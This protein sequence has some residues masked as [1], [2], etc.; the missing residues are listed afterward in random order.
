[1]LNDFAQSFV[2]YLDFEKLKGQSKT[3]K[4]IRTRYKYKLFL[5]RNLDFRVMLLLMQGLAAYEPAAD[6]IEER[7]NSVEVIADDNING[8]KAQLLQR[9]HRFLNVYG[10]VEYGRIEFAAFKHLLRQVLSDMR[11]KKFDKYVKELLKPFSNYWRK[12]KTK[13]TSV[14]KLLAEA[15]CVKTPMRFDQIKEREPLYKKA[16][17]KRM[18]SEVYQHYVRHDDTMDFSNLPGGMYR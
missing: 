17:I 13:H 6:M 7:A 4:D 8:Q 10:R 15:G 9:Y 5:Q 14:H 2:A 11:S 16:M 18:E 3:A 12:L 1:M